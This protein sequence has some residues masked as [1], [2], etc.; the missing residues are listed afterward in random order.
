MYHKMLEY[1]I[2]NKIEQ[3]KINEIIYALYLKQK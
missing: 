3:Q 2:K 1:E